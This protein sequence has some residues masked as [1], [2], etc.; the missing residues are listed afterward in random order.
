MSH[1]T[2]ITSIFSLQHLIQSPTHFSPSGSPSTIDLVFVPL[3]FCSVVTLPPP[4]GTSDHHAISLILSPPPP[5]H[6]H[7]QR[8]C[9]YHRL[10]SIKSMTSSHP[11]TGPLSFLLTLMM[12]LFYE[13]FFNIIH[14]FTLSKLIPLCPLPLWLPH[15]L[16]HKI[17]DHHH[18]F[19]QAKS[20]HSPHAWSSF[21]HF[22]MIQGN[23]LSVSVFISLSI[24]VLCKIP[25]FD[26]CFNPCFV[27]PKLSSHSL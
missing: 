16:L 13:L 1:I 14:Q 10:I 3:S 6:L 12:S 15:P 18:L 27:L 25:L 19:A 7:S 24:L 23:L 8:I 2:T 4:V 5:F 22:V 9:L 21:T 17:Q 20:Q 26:Q 11:L